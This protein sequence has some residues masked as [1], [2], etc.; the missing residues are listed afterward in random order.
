MYYGEASQVLSPRCDQTVQSGLLLVDQHQH[1]N[2]WKSPP[3]PYL[4]IMCNIC[5]FT[6]S[7]VSSYFYLYIY[8]Y[9]TQV[10]TFALMCTAAEGGINIRNIISYRIQRFF[11]SILCT[12]QFKQLSLALFLMRKCI[13]RYF[14]FNK[15]NPQT[16][17]RFLVPVVKT[18]VKALGCPVLGH[19]PKSFWSGQS[20]LRTIIIWLAH[21]SCKL[22][23]PNIYVAKIW[24]H[25]ICLFFCF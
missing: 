8:I 19:A 17:F 14:P 13:Q 4:P 2:S 15:N 21:E 12:V 3:H 10:W 7:L 16:K 1:K 6:L 9:Y 5:I 23:S 11:F 24:Y 25:L 20:W 22:Q 18:A